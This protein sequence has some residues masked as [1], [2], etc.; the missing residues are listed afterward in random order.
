MALV[1]DEMQSDLTM[2]TLENITC[3]TDKVSS[4]NA[5]SAVMDML[6]DA[7]VDIVAL[8]Y[9]KAYDKGHEGLRATKEEAREL[10][11]LAGLPAASKKDSQDICFIPDG[12]YLSFLLRDGVVPQAGRFIG[13][14]GED[15]GPHKGLE[16][17][18]MG[19][20]RGLDVA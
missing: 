8:G 15:L 16:A 3:D 10:A 12:D 18:T 17:Y 1:R 6:A 2:L 13:P 20:R 5:P 7:G 11:G 14:N 19:Q 4:V 9:S